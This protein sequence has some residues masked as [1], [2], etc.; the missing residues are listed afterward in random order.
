MSKKTKLVII[1][2]LLVAS[3]VLSF[4]AGCAL[5]V[6][7]SSSERLG[8]DT[9]EQAWGIIF[10]DYVERDK[11]D[12]SKLS[13][14]AIS[15]MV[16]ALPDPYS[17]YLSADTYQLSRSDV[18]GKFD[19]IGAVVG[20]RDNQLVII[21]PI[22]DSPA[23]KA[24]IKAGDKVLEIDGKPASEMSPDEAALIIR[25]PSGTSVKLLIL[26]EG[27]A[28][29]EE[30]EVI[31]AEIKPSSV[32]F[33]MRG[34]IAYIKIGIFSERTNE[35]LS[36]VL[37]NMA[38]EA[39]AGIVL[40]LRSNPGGALEAV[41]DVAG[42]FLKEGIVTSIIDNQGKQTSLSVK[43][44]AV[45][46]ELPMIVLTDNYSASA[47]ELLTGAL[48]DHARA[49]IAG[50]R[51]YGKGS[52]TVL[53]QLKDGSGLNIT[54]AHFLTPN[55]HLIEGKGIEPDYPLELMGEDAIQWAIDY[56]KR[57]K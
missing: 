1:A 31:R 12:A 17:A 57:N 3:L 16:E 21:A 15:G 45:I 56:L 8:L 44:S 53:N 29:P 6:S 5:G 26:H 42:R 25:G 10:K 23:E 28:Q 20:V 49:T 50:T 38:R 18:A 30:I 40:D 27:D 7:V 19:G 48:K 2:I 33:E 37:E 11:L 43:P 35:E 51:T 13:E 39:A 32:N 24:G 54:V 22:P 34:D 36:L 52:V 9:V 55:G 41:I 4:G 46:T 47:S 14:A